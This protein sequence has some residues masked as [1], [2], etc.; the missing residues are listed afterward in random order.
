[1][2]L[3]LRTGAGHASWA[4]KGHGDGRGRK[5][6]LFL[7]EGVLRGGMGFGPWW[8]FAKT[9]TML[10]KISRQKTSETASCSSIL[11]MKVNFK[12]LFSWKGTWPTMSTQGWDTAAVVCQGCHNQVPQTCSLPDRSSFSHSSGSWKSKIKV[13]AGLF[14]LRPLSWALDAVFFLCLHVVFPPLCLWPYLLFL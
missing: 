4:L 9:S 1:M 13:Q 7:K 11:G 5:S 2:H 10:H 6:K 3:W 14:L 8:E 12:F